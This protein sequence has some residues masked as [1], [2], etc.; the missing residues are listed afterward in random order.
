VNRQPNLWARLTT[1][2][3]RYQQKVITGETFAMNCNE[4]LITFATDKTQFLT[5]PEH[6]SFTDLHKRTFVHFNSIFVEQYG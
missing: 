1:H 6:T 5:S 3:H 4:I 2:S